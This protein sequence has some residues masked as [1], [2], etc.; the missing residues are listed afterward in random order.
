MTT[1]SEEYNGIHARLDQLR[2]RRAVLE[3]EEEKRREA[4][5]KLAGELK[6]AGVDLGD[7]PGEKERLQGEV[8]RLQMEAV[9]LVDEFE[10]KLDTAEQGQPGEP[11][12]EASHTDQ[13][14]EQKTPAGE[15]EID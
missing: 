2:Q 14:A 7:L 5:E 3:A 6:A 9:A 11:T 10:Q 1:P 8:E 15:M 12:Q 13:K 4:R